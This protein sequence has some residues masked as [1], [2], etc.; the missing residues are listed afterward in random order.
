MPALD[1]TEAWE[2]IKNKFKHFAIEFAKEAQNSRQVQIADISEELS[3][4]EDKV[5]EVPDMVKIKKNTVFE[6]IPESIN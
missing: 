1:K 5:A 4:L 6:I 2:L 3:D